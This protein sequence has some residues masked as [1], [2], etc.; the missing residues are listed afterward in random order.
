M[1]KSFKNDWIDENLRVILWTLRI[2]LIAVVAWNIFEFTLYEVG[3]AYTLIRC[4]VT[5]AWL[6]IVI[7][8]CT[9]HYK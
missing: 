1:E 2:I 7:Y 3:L 5:V 6:L 4:I 9:Q 8:S